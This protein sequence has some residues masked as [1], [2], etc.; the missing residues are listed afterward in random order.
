MV[1]ERAAYVGDLHGFPSRLDNINK[2]KID[3]IYFVGDVSGSGDMNN[4]KE[5]YNQIYHGV[6]VAIQNEKRDLV[7]QLGGAFDKTE[8]IKAKLL[9]VKMPVFSDEVKNKKLQEILKYSSYTKYLA[10]LPIDVR[11]KLDLGVRIELDK[12]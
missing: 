3:A 10:K 8:E 12:I 2:Q 7:S 6:G 1:I 5:L 11:E 9:N 4:L